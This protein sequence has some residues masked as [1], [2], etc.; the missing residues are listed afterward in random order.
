MIEDG[1]DVTVKDKKGFNSLHIAAIAGDVEIL[2]LLLN[3]GML[4]KINDQDWSG[5]TPL[6][7]ICNEGWSDCAQLLLEKGANCEIVNEDAVC[8][9]GGTRIPM[10]IT[11]G[12]SPLSFAA[13]R[14]EYETV[15]VLLSFN[16]KMKQIPDF[17]GNTPYQL[18]LLSRWNETAELLKP[19]EESVT[20]LD[21][22]VIQSKR[23]SD[24]KIRASRINRKER[25]KRRNVQS[26]IAKLYKPKHPDIY[27]YNTSF[28]VSSFNSILSDKVIYS[29][30]TNKIK[31]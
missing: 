24:H 28:F 27:I 20:S 26:D 14:G 16:D 18:A 11:G 9:I 5:M 6:H 25:E 8:Y 12:K 31:M 4:S 1:F 29:F 22:D 13:E 3:N 23:E 19:T 2:S 17:D 21:I 15:N 10:Y 7:Y 30:L